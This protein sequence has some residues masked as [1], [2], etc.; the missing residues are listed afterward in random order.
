MGFAKSLEVTYN[1]VTDTFHPHLHIILVWE[2]HTKI[3]NLTHV[4]Q[5]DWKEVNGVD[6]FP[7][8]DHK[9]IENTTR[10]F[11]TNKINKAVLETFKYCTKTK[12]LEQMPLKAFRDIAQQ[13]AGHRLISYGGII[14]DIAKLIEE[15]DKAK[16]DTRETD[17][18]QCGKCSKQMLLSVLRWS[19]DENTYK[20]M[21]QV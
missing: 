6:Y 10:N 2:K 8:V 13:L 1:A 20:N 11:E 12:D 4:F 18:I 17:I 16:D 7:Q 15:Q 21:G 14:K 3:S 5:L 9:E 19:F